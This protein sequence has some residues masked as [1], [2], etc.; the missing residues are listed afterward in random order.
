MFNEENYLEVELTDP[1]KFL[2][3]KETLTRM[4]VAS[5][6]KKNLYQSCHILFKRGKYYIVHFKQMFELDDLPTTIDDVDYGRRNSIAQTLE[7][8]GLCKIVN[9][10]ILKEN[11]SRF[12]V[13]PFKEKE[14]W[15]LIA[16][17]SFGKHD[18]SPSSE[19]Q[20]QYC[21]FD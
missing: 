7:K 16:K 2:I 4:G 11:F 13:I 10:A 9:P 21:D 20:P 1:S 3:I 8:W 14:D 12:Y 19:D 17:Y 6:E 15:N 18:D 5:R